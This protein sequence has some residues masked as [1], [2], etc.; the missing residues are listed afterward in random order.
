MQYSVGVRRENDM[1]DN[2]CRLNLVHST[3]DDPQHNLNM[4]APVHNGT[5]LK[6][7]HMYEICRKYYYDVILTYETKPCYF[8]CKAATSYIID[9]KTLHKVVS[10]K[11]EYF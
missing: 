3:Q 8:Q 2:R 1:N 4:V 9:W 11:R 6:A 10:L 5:Y 7:S